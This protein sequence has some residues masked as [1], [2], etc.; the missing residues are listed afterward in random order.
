MITELQIR[1]E[2]CGRADFI[3]VAGGFGECPVCGERVRLAKRRVEPNIAQRRKYLD[4][5]AGIVADL[6]AAA[7][8]P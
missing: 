1:C 6:I 7:K 4:D 3:W 5:T 2:A 8:M